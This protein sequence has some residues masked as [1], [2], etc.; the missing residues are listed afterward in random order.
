M[1]NRQRT[2]IVSIA[3]L[4][5]VCLAYCGI[6]RFE[7]VHYDDNTH[8][9][10]NERVSTGLSLG[11]VGWAFRQFNGA[12]WIPLT[13]LSFM[14]DVSLFGLNP[15][16]MHSV[17]IALHALN[18]VLL[19]LL[20]HRLTRE[21]WPAAAVAAIYALHPVNVE[22]VA[23]L[24]E[25]KNVLSTVF[26]LLS[27]LS[28]VRYAEGRRHAWM[29]ACFLCLALGLMVKAML[30]TLPCTLLLLDAWPLGRNRTTSW[31]RLVLEKLPLFALSALASYL[32]MKAAA[33][34]GLLWEGGDAPSFAYRAM[35]AGANVLQY[36]RLIFIPTDYAPM[37]PLPREI[38]VAMGLAGW[39]F[40]AA[41]LA[42]GWRLRASA[43]YV[44]VGF[45]WF[46]GTQFPVSGIVGA[47]DAVR[48]DRYLYIP[49]IGILIAI[50]WALQKS[51][52]KLSREA[53][54]TLAAVILGT[55]AWL[56]HET[57]AHWRNTTALATHATA[58]SPESVPAHKLAGWVFAHD[59]KFAE[60]LRH[61]DAALH[62][63]P[64]HLE[65][66]CSRAVV[67]AK[68]GRRESSIAEFRTILAA[69]PDHLEAKVN[70]GMQLFAT[71]DLP[72]ARAILAQ[73]TTPGANA[74]TIQYWLA[75]IAHLEGKHEEAKRRYTEALQLAKDEPWMDEALDWMKL[76]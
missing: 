55:L 33:N 30:V 52:A 19:F 42:L 39:A 67:L 66:R 49:E 48:C 21:F 72:Q 43:P 8:I 27:T 32:Q 24:S 58:V 22:S 3:L 4:V 59:G 1:P 9:F 38:P 25:R 29:L 36:M 68:L 7:F 18:A 31:P 16:A 53:A 76:L 12:Q 61:Y 51:V 56:T 44:L 13:W 57:A 45:L 5:A 14:A 65:I 40:S 70:L 74:A 10:G 60:A 69:S 64:G 46:L 15:G 41:T 62:L 6:W 17:N 11:N 34:D 26:W 37:L 47:G 20:L 63:A 75:R 28:Y 2:L 73:I 23:W 50:V 35:N 71:G 54:F